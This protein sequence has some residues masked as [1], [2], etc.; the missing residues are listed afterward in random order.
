[1]SLASAGQPT[2]EKQCSGWSYWS[3]RDIASQTQLHSP[4][5]WTGTSPTYSPHRNKNTI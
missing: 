5:Q 4:L 2:T 1:M 3:C